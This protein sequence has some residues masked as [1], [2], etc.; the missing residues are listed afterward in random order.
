MNNF[1]LPPCDHPTNM[2][3]LSN[4][5]QIT[6]IGANGSGK[7]RFMEELMELCLP[8]TYC[9][10]VLTAF[11][12][13]RSESTLSGS[14][15]A[16]YRD[17]VCRQPYLRPDAVSQLDK[18][19][20]L[21]FADELSE[22]F[23]L[24]GGIEGRTH[25]DK[26][27]KA[28]GISSSKQK[29]K[30]QKNGSNGFTLPETKMD[31]VQRVWERIFPGNRIVRKDGRMMFETVSG[32]DLITADRLSQGEKAALY[33]LAGVIF[34]M[35]GAV[36]FI[37]SPTLFIHPAIQNRLW[38][39]IEELRPDCTFVYNSVDVDFVTSR[40]RNL[41]IWIQG[42]DAAHNNWKYQLLKGDPI[43]DNLMVELAGSRRPVLFIE[44]DD[45]HSI[46]VRLYS[47][48]FQDYTVR[49]LGS[50]NKVIETTRSFND[51]S[52]MHHLLSGGIVDRDRRTDQEV[53]Y[54][55]NKQIMVPEVAEI[56]NIFMLPVVVKVMADRRGRNGNRIVDRMKRD[57]IR[58]FKAHAD[59]QALQHTRHI[60]KREVEC[61]IDAR[62]SCITA[63]E[64]H[65]RQLIHKLKPREHYNRL[66]QHF[67]QIVLEQD[68]QAILKV[69]N[70]KPMISSCNIHT[71]LGFKSVN[72][73]I[74]GVLDVLKSHGNDSDL[75]R[76][77]VLHILKADNPA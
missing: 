15:D 52:S 30:K 68:Y 51:L 48:V 10:N 28:Q 7:S 70:Y 59:E 42:Y 14:I 57:V 63:M 43:P 9:L 16:L 38:D 24:K 18:I 32:T 62:F 61:K 71:Q 54:L 4:T 69:F 40:T 23:D 41:T 72:D 34:A 37:D 17:A 12:A 75:I 45:R 25:H 65:I 55:R 49:P 29:G 47:L 36:I 8:H 26:N 22:L 11:F 3:D 44:G 56:E 13:E 53:D 60:I 35:P 46:D 74:N 76:N 39:N 1:R 21:L 6:I 50:C 64:T 31:R 27:H 20:Y 2:P 58:L 77:A 73:Y 67:A 19:L 5:R 66:R 33:Y